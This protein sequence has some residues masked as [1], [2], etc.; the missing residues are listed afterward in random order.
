M[1]LLK[2]MVQQNPKKFFHYTT[3]FKADINVGSYYFDCRIFLGGL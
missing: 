2:W 1:K 3:P